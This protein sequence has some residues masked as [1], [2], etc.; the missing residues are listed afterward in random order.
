MQGR[1]DQIKTMLERAR[2]RGEKPPAL[3]DVLD[4]LL[5]PLYTRALFGTPAN[6]AFAEKLVERLMRDD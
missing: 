6:E 5:A 4:H 1:V 2:K 3:A